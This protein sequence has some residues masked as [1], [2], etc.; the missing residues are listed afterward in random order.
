MPSSGR[1]RS[2]F[3]LAA[4]LGAAFALGV[5]QLSFVREPPVRRYVHPASLGLCQDMRA[6]FY[7]FYYFNQFPVGAYFDD[8]PPT[9]TEQLSAFVKAHPERLVMDFSWPC[10][11]A[12]YGDYGKIFLFIPAALARGGPDSPSVRLFNILFFVVALEAALLALWRHGYPMLG[13]LLALLVGSDPF[14]LFEVYLHDNILSLP[15]STALLTLAMHVRFLT[16]RAGIDRSAWAIPAV[17]GVMLASMR[18]V[19]TEP[20]LMVAALPFVYLTVPRERLSKR[21]GLVLVLAASYALTAHAWRLYFDRKFEDA[22]AFVTKAGGEPYTGP[23]SQYHTVWHNLF[24]GLGDFGT[25]LGYRWDDRAA[26]AY[27]TPILQQRYGRA[28]TYGGTGYY[29]QQS[30]DRRGLYR[31][32]PLDFPEYEQVLRAKVLGDVLR[33]PMWYLGILRMRVRAIMWYT[34]PVSVAHGGWRAGRP[35]SGWFA[36]PTLLGV[37]LWRKPFF[38]K[39]LCFTF[40]LSLTPLLIFSGGGTTHYAIFHLVTLCVWAQIVLDTLRRV[41][42]RRSP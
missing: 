4:A 20:A 27:A 30:Y 37:A 17:S 15:I 13:I 36:V 38:V 22:K 7:F 8:P 41:L 6:F 25:Q 29:F 5:W 26:Y 14:Q 39:L 12:R 3:N 18:E 16:G 32:S 1:R 23:R 9:T 24:V 11:T 28:V 35:F 42:P 10:N 31:V 33:H 21:V 34:T 40:P 19:R 2:W